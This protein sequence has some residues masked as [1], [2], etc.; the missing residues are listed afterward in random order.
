MDETI[1]GR[2]D[3]GRYVMSVW[4]F[5]LV[6]AG[7]FGFGAVLA[8]VR[9]EDPSQQPLVYITAG[10]CLIIGLV[11][12]GWCAVQYICSARQLTVTPTGAS[13]VVKGRAGSAK[14]TDVREFYRDEFYTVGPGPAAARERSEWMRSAHVRLVFRD[15]TEVTFRQTL[16]NYDALVAAMQRYAAEAVL[17][18]KIA[19]VA[20]GA[21]AEFGPLEVSSAGL[22]I[23]GKLRL[24]DEINYA[25]NNGWLCVA[26]NRDDFDIQE[27]KD[28]TLV[29]IPN[30]LALL[31]LMQQV[32]K[33]PADP[34]LLYPKSWR[35]SMSR[36][37]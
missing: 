25:V 14:W 26:P 9:H 21:E 18:E 27:R 28:F 19:L 24:W 17:V 33:P 22:R 37:M 3:F 15:G 23:K 2:F 6:G 16:S 1:E 31:A 12:L 11:A 10:A 4:L 34:L 5:F 13:W 20:A 36:W 8:G 7:A 35:E 30:Y 32:G 29:T